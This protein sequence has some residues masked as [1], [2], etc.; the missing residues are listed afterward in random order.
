MN[1]LLVVPSCFDLEN[2]NSIF[3]QCNCRQKLLYENLVQ[4]PTF[5]LTIR[6]PFRFGICFAKKINLKKQRMLL[7]SQ[8]RIL[9][10]GKIRAV[11]KF[12]R[13]TVGKVSCTAGHSRVNHCWPKR[14]LL[15][16]EH[17]PVL[18]SKSKDRKATQIFEG[19]LEVKLPTMWTVGKAEVGRN[20][21]EKSRSE[22]SR[23]EKGWEARRCGCAKR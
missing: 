2:D 11:R 15:A 13:P 22:K 19:N 17:W 16:I 6:K 8:C 10:W 21:K 14:G 12:G 18:V 20:R 23:E 1:V 7:G 9:L 3:K 5:R 4:I